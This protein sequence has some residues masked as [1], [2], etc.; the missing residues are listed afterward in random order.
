MAVMK[1]TGERSTGRGRGTATAS[2]RP[3][4]RLRGWVRPGSAPPSAVARERDVDYAAAPAPPG[5]APEASTVSPVEADPQVGLVDAAEAVA[6]LRWANEVLDVVDLDR[7]RDRELLAF[8][9]DVDREITRI[10]AREARLVRA[11]GLRQ[12][13]A[14]DGCVT[15]AS[16]LR[17]KTNRDPGD[18]T[19]LAK[20]ARRLAFLDVTRDAVEAGDITWRHAEVIATAAIPQ[21]RDAIV[22]HEDTLVGLAR[23]AQPRDVRAACRKIADVVS[24]DHGDSEGCGPDSRRELYSTRTF[25]G[26]GDLRANLDPVTQEMFE[27]LL[28]AFTTPDE[29]ETPDNQQRTPAQVRHDAFDAILSAASEHPDVGSVHGAKPHVLLMIDLQTLL[30]RDDLA[31]RK[32]RLGSGTELSV[33]RAVHLL[34]QAKLTPVLMLG[35]YRAVGFGRTQ[36]VLPDWLRPLLKAVHGHCRGPGCDRPFEW[37][38]AM[39]VNGDYAEGATTEFDCTVPGCVKHHQLRDEHG[40]QVDY[41]PDTAICTWTSPDRLTV[42]HTHPPDP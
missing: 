22:D 25:E 27:S 36:R 42:I 29:T 39:H 24:P 4:G 7:L 30:G 21:R 9:R 26:F 3:S 23:R 20:T 18:A 16:W 19:R 34:E 41:D 32:P 14:E 8:T 6:A 5:S 17:Q 1:E 11:V 13:Y 15:A 33:E 40:W 10:Q 37:T 28:H 31:T 12:A 38:Q 35:P 2:G